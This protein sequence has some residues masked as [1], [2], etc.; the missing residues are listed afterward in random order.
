MRE[1]KSKEINGVTF[2]VTQLGFKSG[3]AVFMRVSKLI[4]PSLAALAHGAPSLKTVTSEALLTA[5]SKALMTVN[6]DDLE[7]LAS[8]FGETT[9]FHKGDPSK[10]PFLKADNR[11]ELFS[12]NLVLFFQWL[13]F[14]LE[15]N[16]SD[17]L[18]AWA[19]LSASAPSQ[20]TPE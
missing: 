5:L 13:M 15:V 18:A 11:E 2:E 9:R 20:D 16:F 4:G 14:C 19:G 10:S 12:G 7:Y 3:R 17:F 6:D 1:V 8:Q